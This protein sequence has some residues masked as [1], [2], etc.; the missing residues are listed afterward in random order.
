MRRSPNRLHRTKCA[1]DDNATRV[2]PFDYQHW[3]TVARRHSRRASDAPDLLQDS[4]IDALR[5]GR[6][7]FSNEATKRWFAG[8][9]R[10]RAAMQA[11][12]EGRRKRRE[13]TVAGR[14]PS[15]TPPQP[16][17][18]DLFVESLPPSARRVAV[19]VIAGLNRDEIVAALKIAP[20]AFRQRLATIRRTWTK[21]P[22]SQRDQLSIDA[23]NH[24]NGIDLG[25]LRQALLA[26]VRRL[27]GIGTHDPDGHLI[28][29]SEPRSQDAPSRQQKRKEK[30]NG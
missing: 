21:L 28:V 3:L 15:T 5:V 16:V 19:L 8:V 10:N 4:L 13:A 2:E 14:V 11:R 23:P 7:D 22:A 26:N 6:T 17:P 29:L 12:G 18:A 24:V 20:T 30:R 9:I 27:G 1:C 25:L